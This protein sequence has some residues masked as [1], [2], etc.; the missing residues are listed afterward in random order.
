MRQNPAWS[1][2]LRSS[3]LV[4][5]CSIPPQM[6]REPRSRGSSSER[7]NQREKTGLRRKPLPEGSGELQPGSKRSRSVALPIHVGG[8]EVELCARK[9]P[10]MSSS[11]RGWKV[12]RLG[13]CRSRN[14]Q[15]WDM[16]KLYAWHR[17]QRAHGEDRGEWGGRARSGRRIL[18]QTRQN[19]HWSSLAGWCCR[20][21]FPARHWRGWIQ[22]AGGQADVTPASTSTRFYLWW[23][24]DD[25]LIMTKIKW[26]LS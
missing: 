18:E 7:T 8:R 15:I 14:L 4:W 13:S 10:L 6:C 24:R 19:T 16:T 2:A 17:L 25:Q 21:I 11:S 1:W 22:P 5:R 26:R 3:Q 9:V 12:N 20:W 23:K